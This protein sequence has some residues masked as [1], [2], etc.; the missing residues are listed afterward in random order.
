MARWRAAGL[1]E[2][3]SEGFVVRASESFTYDEFGS[4]VMKWV[5][6]GHVQTSEH[7]MHQELV[8]NQLRQ[9]P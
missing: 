8:L 6:K 3:T 4:N 7:W 9:H 2:H 1:D 5:R